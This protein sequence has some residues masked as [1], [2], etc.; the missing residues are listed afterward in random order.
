MSITVS[1]YLTVEEGGARKL[2][3]NAIYGSTT[4]EELE[5]IVKVFTRDYFLNVDYGVILGTVNICKFDLSF[6]TIDQSCDYLIFDF[7]NI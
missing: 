6:G 5:P 7:G 3:Y 2:K 4:G 1:P